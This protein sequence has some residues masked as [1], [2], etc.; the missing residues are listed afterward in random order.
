MDNYYFLDW[1]FNR[2]TIWRGQRTYFH[3]FMTFY[4]KDFCLKIAWWEKKNKAIQSHGGQS[5]PSL[6]CASSRRLSQQDGPPPAVH[7]SHRILKKAL[8]ICVCLCLSVSQTERATDLK[9]ERREKCSLSSITPSPPNLIKCTRSHQLHNPNVLSL[10]LSQPTAWQ[11]EQR[12]SAQSFTLNFI[13]LRTVNQ[14]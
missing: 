12:Q 7:L 2:Q 14:I 10:F 1:L 11:M 8:S 13:W 5:M 4:S 3:H 9:E 6:L